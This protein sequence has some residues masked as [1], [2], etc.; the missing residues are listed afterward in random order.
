VI[1]GKHL[2]YLFPSVRWS[3]QKNRS[4][5][6]NWFDPT[7]GDSES[8]RATGGSSALPFLES[9]SAICSHLFDGVLSGFL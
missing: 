1:S 4:N 6:L 2:C 9:T 8:G 5:G 7:V 3:E